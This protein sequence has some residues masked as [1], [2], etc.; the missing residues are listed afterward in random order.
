MPQLDQVTYFSQFFWLCI[1]YFTFY[2]FVVKLYLPK[3]SRILKLRSK[4]MNKDSN[5][6]HSEES[7]EIN[8]LSDYETIL[9][10]GIKESRDF[11][12][13]NLEGT[14]KNVEQLNQKINQNIL[15][16]ANEEYLQSISNLNITS[17]ILQN[18]LSL[19][20]KKS[21]LANETKVIS[22]YEIQLLK[23]VLKK[24]NINN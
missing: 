2:V 17:N 6:S 19:F 5:I 20:S 22:L 15:R 8:S 3:I 11:L 4:K 14:L 9:L 12:A 10:T 7:T 1:F 16:N 21:I 18:D 24:A 23:S 13:Q